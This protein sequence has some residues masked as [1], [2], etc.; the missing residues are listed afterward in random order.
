MTAAAKRAVLPMKEARRVWEQLVDLPQWDALAVEPIIAAAIT[1]A[2][3]R[4]RDAERRPDVGEVIAFGGQRYEVVDHREGWGK[5]KIPCV[6]CG[7]T[8]QL[9]WN[10]GELD[11]QECCGHRYYTHHAQVDLYVIRALRTKDTQ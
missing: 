6:V 8:I 4:G 10:G 3:Q 9:F 11:R 7:K 5:G 2:E 1:T